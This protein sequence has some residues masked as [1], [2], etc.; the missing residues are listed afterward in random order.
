MKYKHNQTLPTKKQT[1]TT[2]PNVAET[3]NKAA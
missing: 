3:Y 1:N 2:E